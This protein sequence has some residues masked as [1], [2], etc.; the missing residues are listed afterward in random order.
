MAAT[1]EKIQV[2]PHPDAHITEK[3]E[4]AEAMRG[5]H[6][7][8]GSHDLDMSDSELRRIRRHLDWRIVP[9]LTLLYLLSF[10]DRVNIGELGIELAANTMY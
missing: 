10:L 4:V 5:A 2:P 8:L 9:F 7:D 3:G 1:R 6:E